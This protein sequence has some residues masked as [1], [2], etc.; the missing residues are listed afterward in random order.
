MFITRN[1]QNIQFTSVM[2]EVIVFSLG[3]KPKSQYPSCIFITRN[4]KL[5]N[6]VDMVDVQWSVANV[7][8]R[9]CDLA[10]IVHRTEDTKTKVV[11]QYV[12]GGTVVPLNF[13]L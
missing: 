2:F 7:L 8:L 1:Q 6:T 9:I 11:I 3:Q 13:V 12:K 10:N 4:G 5:N